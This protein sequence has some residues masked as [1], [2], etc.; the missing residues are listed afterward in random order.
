MAVPAARRS[1]RVV[2]ATLFANQFVAPLVVALL[3][4]RPGASGPG[5]ELFVML[6]GVV[7]TLTFHVVQARVLRRPAAVATT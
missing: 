2:F 7:T 5:L 6:A 4:T 1:N 3:L